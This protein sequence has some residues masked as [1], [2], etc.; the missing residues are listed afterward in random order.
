MKKFL[1]YMMGLLAIF[2]C[3]SQSKSKS[4]VVN[5]PS[6]VRDVTLTHFDAVVY[7]SL[8]KAGRIA[9]I[10]K[11]QDAEKFLGNSEAGIKA[12]VQFNHAHVNRIYGVLKTYHHKDIIY[13]IAQ[14]ADFMGGNA[15]YLITYN[16][17]IDDVVNEMVCFSIY[18]N[19][20]HSNEIKTRALGQS[21]LFKIETQSDFDSETEEV[22]SETSYELIYVLEDG[23]LEINQEKIKPFL[24]DSVRETLRVYESLEAKEVQNDFA[25]LEAEKIVSN[26]DLSE[27]L[28]VEIGYASSILG[29]LKSNQAGVEYVVLATYLNN[30]NAYSLYCVSV[31]GEGYII[32]YFSF[33]EDWKYGPTESKITIEGGNGNYTVNSIQTEGEEITKTKQKITF[34]PNGYFKID[35]IK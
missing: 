5:S 26:V 7:D 2:G 22:Q 9:G 17:Q 33:M 20:G 27:F 24:T 3:K 10:D 16:L 1:Y 19:A 8:L 25:S 23:V 12:D 21:N 35:K 11:I 4:V 34:L 13:L 32:D 28:V 18:D 29:K 15:L 31:D 14:D 30:L 6:I